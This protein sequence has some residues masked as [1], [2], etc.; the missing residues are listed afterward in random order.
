MKFNKLVENIV[1]ASKLRLILIRGVPGSGK[2]TYA[3]KLMQ[4]DPNLSHYEA[5]MYFYNAEGEY[6]FDPKRLPEAHAWCKRKTAEDLRNG[7]SVIV[8][9]TFSQKWEIKSYIKL[10]EEYGAEIIIKKATGN[11]RNVHNVSDEIVNKMKSR[12]QDV[13]GETLL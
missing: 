10:G 6:Q 8:S 3:K 1:S 4:E 11:Y 2:S 13:E 12:W 9:N 7:K 5:D